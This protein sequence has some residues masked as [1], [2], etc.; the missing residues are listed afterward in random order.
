MVGLR[1]K[2]NEIQ[3]ETWWNYFFIFFYFIIFSG[4]FSN[5]LD[6]FLKKVMN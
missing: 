4:V 2:W 1:R 6:K 5:V 3:P